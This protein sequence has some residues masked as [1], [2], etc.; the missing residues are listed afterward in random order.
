MS[1]AEN[2]ATA[3]RGYAAFTERDVAAAMTDLVDDIEWITPGNSAIS[4]TTHGKQELGANWA[5]LA[6]KGFT[7]SPQHWFADEERV[8]VLTQIS[9]GGESADSADVLT[10]N[11]DGKVIK[12]QT[13]GD[14]AL[15]ER[16]FGA[17]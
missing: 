2:I 9:V 12:F 8:V 17:K 13:A 4:G 3:K 5:K 16:V 6:E 1:A 10:Y 15:F 7:T 11:A 14:T